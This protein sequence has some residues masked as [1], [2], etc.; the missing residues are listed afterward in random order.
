MLLTQAG[1]VF[2]GFILFISEVR[3]Q[4]KSICAVKGSS[5]DLLC[6]A[7][8]PT[9][10]MK[11]FTVHWNHFEFV[12]N[13]LST[14]GNVMY[15]ISE[16]NNLTLTIKHL[17]ESDAKFYCCSE[18]TE[19]AELCWRNR[20]ELLVADLQVKVIPATEEQTVTLMCSTSCPLTENPAA[21][22][23]Y[24]NR[25]LLY[26]DWSPWYRELVS[27]EEAVSYSCAIKGYEDQRAPEVSVDSVTSTCFNVTYAKGRMCSY[28]NNSEDE[29]CSFTY[30]TEL[31]VQK[32]KMNNRVIITCNSSCP[33][34]DPQNAYVWYW[35]KE[36]YT[37]CESQH[38]TVLG[39]FYQVVSCAI[40]GHKY[41]HS[42][43][44]CPKDSHCWISNY[45]SRRMCAL[46]GFSVNISVQYSQSKD[47][48]IPVEPWYKI[49]IPGEHNV[50]NGSMDPGR[51]EYDDN[52]INLHMLRITN[53]E[54]SD[55]GLYVF[56]DQYG[57]IKKS[58][59]SGVIL[60]VT[61]LTVTMTPSAVVTQGQRVTLTCG[62][63]C[64]LPE[65]TNYMWYLNS[66]PLTPPGNRNKHLVLDPVGTQ[67]AGNYF[68]NV[69]TPHNVSSSEQA[70]TV[71]PLAK[72]VSILNAVKLI[73]L[74]LIL[75]AVFVLYRL[76][77]KRKTLTSTTE[78][79]DTD[80][81]Q[82]GQDMLYESIALTPINPAT[83]TEPAEQQEDTV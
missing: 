33:A 65:D 20:T 51:V 52:I 21:Y 40:K 80:K 48:R 72:S 36:L 2:V 50:G 73:I 29:P 71:I 70:L 58:D 59:L 39:S 57:K 10:S 32:T 37:D 47:E 43:N 55:S 4:G 38:V 6:S 18:T 49:N 23:W 13:E 79:S 14:V 68:C 56:K 67:H 75:P 16:E 54:K 8:H 74:L 53:L 25:K 19:E 17:R 5:V 78:L 82:T 83:P 28:Q 3:G 9:S 46:E 45:V 42:D 26:Q 63:S 64:P 24:K 7:E 22:I 62:T 34:A 60:V 12:L 31:Q 76:M 27:S 30:P 66:R 44:I 35:N 81:V 61:G 11:W 69:P 1:C 41:L 15:N 77:R